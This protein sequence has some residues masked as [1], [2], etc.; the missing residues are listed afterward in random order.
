MKS[1]GPVV[2]EDVAKR[3][4]VAIEEV[5]QTSPTAD[6][7]SHKTGKTA[8]NSYFSDNAFEFSRTSATENSHCPLLLSRKCHLQPTL[9][10]VILFNIFGVL[11][12]SQTL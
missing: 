4:R 9:S 2:A 5:L 7:I 10:T 11:P 8:N 6:L 3:F 1:T 12:V